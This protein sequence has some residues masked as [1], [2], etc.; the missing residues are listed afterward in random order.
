MND[1]KKELK[2]FLLIAG[3]SYYPQSG[4][5]DWIGAFETK[6]E[7]ESK[8]IKAGDKRIKFETY[9][10]YVIENIGYDWFKIVDLKDWIK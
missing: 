3:H 5:Q 8:V 10:P 4:T 7:A 1:T 9:Y 6:E 2:L